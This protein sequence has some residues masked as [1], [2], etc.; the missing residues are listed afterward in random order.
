MKRGVRNVSLV[1]IERISRGLRVSMYN[2]SH[3]CKK[4]REVGAPRLTRN[5]YVCY[6]PVS[7]QPPSLLQFPIVGIHTHKLIAA[8]LIL[9]P[10]RLSPQDGDRRFRQGE[11]SRWTCCQ[12]SRDR[13]VIRI[14]MT[15]WAVVDPDIL[16]ASEGHKS[17]GS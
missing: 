3:G 17:D 7:S 5:V 2:C 8:G 4:R 6:K 1:N 10:R 16:F 12:S 11:G 14:G 13:R 15:V 9:E